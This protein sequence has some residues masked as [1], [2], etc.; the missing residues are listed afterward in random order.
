MSPH[1]RRWRVPESRLPFVNAEIAQVR[2]QGEPHLVSSI[3]GGEGGGRIYFWNPDTGIRA[4]RPLPDGIPGAYMLKTAADGRLYLGCGRGELVRYDPDADA[5]E[6][7][8]AGAMSSIT[9]G[10][11]VTDRYAVW[12]ASP[13][14]V[15]VYDWR[16]ERLVKVF[17]PADIETP[18]AL[19]GHRVIEAPDGKVIVGMNVPRARLIVLDLEAMDVRSV[20]PAA[21]EG[22]S[23]T[24][25]A[26]FFDDETLALF[27]GDADMHMAV[28]ALLR[29]P[30]FELIDRVPAPE[31]VVQLGARACFVGDRFYALGDPDHT[32]YRLDVAARRWDPVVEGWT[33]EETAVLSPWGDESVCAVSTSGLAHRYDVGTGDTDVLDLDAVGPMGVHALCPAPEAGLIVGAPFI[34]Q[35]FW[36]IDVDT[37]EGRD[38]GR[39]APGGGQVNQIVWDAT[40]RRALMS[41]Y[42]TSSVTAFDPEQP[43][44][45]PDNPRLLA[46]AKAHGQMRPMALEHDGRHVWMATSPNYGSLG[47]AL[48]RI[49]PHSG[50]IRVW[51]HLVP[52]QRVNAIVLDTAR[53]RL[54]A[55][56]DVYADCQSAPPTQTTGH[57]VAFDMDTLAVERQQAVLPDV[58]AV[59]VRALL[60]SGEVLVEAD[61]NLFAWDAGAGAIRPLGPAPGPISVTTDADGVLWASVGG[62]GI[63]RLHVEADSTRFETLLDETGTDL[64]IA[65]DTLYYAVGY[66]I[67][68]VAL[69]ELRQR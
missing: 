53:R 25:D 68:A 11:C 52:D 31:G 44:N 60:P 2:F 45:W 64:S 1:I 29:Y 21:L 63:G 65:N 51:R 34:N 28:L 56:T 47:G 3:W 6:M 66:E 39:A 33:G 8:V 30:G 69:E 40:A 61:G 16:D 24:R 19:Y 46:D 15:A 23:W 48:C 55:S 35:R 10:G 27:Y 32:L 14:H 17:R 43:P 59:S 9:W 50:E 67:H 26:T 57:M 5:F 4:E 41:S 20:T 13:G 58:P 18:A 54:Y 38:C 62:W 37:G 12:S 49:D 22:S 7:L 36:T 42:T